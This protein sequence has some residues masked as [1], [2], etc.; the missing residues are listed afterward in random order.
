MHS[1]SLAKKAASLL[2]L[3]LCTSTAWAHHG[4]GTFDAN[5]CFVFKGTVRQVAWVNPHAWIYVEVEKPAGAS[6][7]WGFEFSAF[8]ALMRAGFKSSDF[9]HGT[10]LTVTAYSNR[11]VEKHTGSASKLVMAD[12]R[13]AGGSEVAGTAPAGTDSGTAALNCPDYK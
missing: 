5:K 8:G 9:A 4:G 7:L 1:N 10:K 3:S 13:Q 2:V 12:G 11:A 6:E